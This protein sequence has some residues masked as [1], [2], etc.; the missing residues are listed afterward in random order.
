M[1]TETPKPGQA[2]IPS[3]AL[4]LG[5]L[6]PSTASKLSASNVTEIQ[7]QR[8]RE[9]FEQIGVRASHEH[10][11]LPKVGRTVTFSENPERRGGSI[12]DDSQPGDELDDG[13][14]IL[15][16]LCC[17]RKARSYSA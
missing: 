17:R 12:S 4:P 8:E 14:G 3:G 7:Y 5:I 13:S 10:E 15:E 6:H 2:G 9:F 1:P 16:G 11:H